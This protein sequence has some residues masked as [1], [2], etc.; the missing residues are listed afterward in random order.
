MA[1]QLVGSVKNPQSNLQD[2]RPYRIVL[3]HPS[4]GVNWS[5]G[6]EIFAIE[7]AKR[8]NSYFQVELLSGAN[9]GSFC[10][11]AGG[12]PRVS[13]YRA[14]RHPLIAPLLHR[15]ATHPEIVI[16]HLTSFLPCAFRCLSNPADL[17]FPCND[18]G[19]LAMAVFV[20][21][22]IG[23]PI[24]FT[25]HVGLMGGGR[26]LIRNLR[27]Q[28]NRL[29]VFSDTV[30]TFVRTQRPSQPVTVIPNGVDLEK[31]TPQGGCINF[32]LPKPIVLCVA[33]LKYNSHKRVE[34]AMQAMR[35]LPQAS[36]LLCGDGPDRSYFQAL[37]EQLLG[38][39]RFAICTFPYERMP[40][41]YR[42]VDV[43][44]LP[45]VDE[46]FGLAY[47]EAMA[48]GLPVVATDDEMRR[49]IVGDGGIVCDVTNPETYAAAILEA[50]SDTAWRMR[51][52]QNASRFSWEQVTLLYRDVILETIAQSKK[53]LLTSRPKKPGFSTR[54]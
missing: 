23:T 49:Y 3:V 17:I 12:V 33:S 15:F 53:G 18:Y 21:A 14:V 47:V 51:S 29:V 27:F 28:P 36:L 31:F 38:S 22:L 6:S 40:E 46:P 42:S 4:V 43:F 9:C 32:H 16:E 19:G 10:Y 2:E 45:S 1:Q 7:I 39:E 50:L 13:A 52:R 34:L 20:R 26:S 8:L 5:G 11:P 54:N 30:A 41:V 35:R 25:E 37:G 48:S 24:L 44:T